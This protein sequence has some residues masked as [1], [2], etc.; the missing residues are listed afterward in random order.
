MI[1]NHFTIKIVNT[2]GDLS[3]FT[4]HEKILNFYGYQRFGSKRPVLQM[5]MKDCEHLTKFDT[6]SG[7]VFL[8]FESFCTVCSL[9]FFTNLVHHIFFWSQTG[10]RSFFSDPFG[11]FRGTFRQVLDRF[12]VPNA[13]PVSFW[14]RSRWLLCPRSRGLGFLVFFGAK[15]RGKLGKTQ[16]SPD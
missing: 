8:V 10:Q 16:E 3:L 12:H 4:E 1:Q 2:K 9:S 7:S 5:V 13:G 6:K 11:T 14:P 15:L